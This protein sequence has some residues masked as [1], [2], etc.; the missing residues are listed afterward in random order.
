MKPTVMYGLPAELFLN[1]QCGR[2]YWE[3][4]YVC[5][6]PT[7]EELGVEDGYVVRRCPHCDT[8]ERTLIKQKPAQRKEA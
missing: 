6:H 7:I 3:V 8:I 5:N 2:V 4:R 1:P